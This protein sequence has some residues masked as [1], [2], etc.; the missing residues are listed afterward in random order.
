MRPPRNRGYYFSPPPPPPPRG[1]LERTAAWLSENRTTIAVVIAFAGTTAFLVHRRKKAHTRKRRAKRFPNGS[2]RELVVLAC[3]SFQDPLTRSLALDLERRGYIVF[4]TVSSHEEDSL[5][6]E[7][8]KPDIR[9]LSMDLTST[10]PNPLQDIHPSLEPIRELITRSSGTS[11]PDST[12][13]RDLQGQPMKLSGIVILPGCSGYPNAALVCLPPTDIVDT[14]NARILAP[15]LTVQQFLPLLLSHSKDAQS[16]SAIVLAYPSIAMS[17]SPPNQIPEI[18]TTSSLS[19]F[20]GS[21]RRELRST[22]ANIHVTELKLGNFDFGSTY[23]RSTDRSANAK[24]LSGQQFSVTHWHSS[25]RAA[26]QRTHLGQSSLIKGSS[27]REFHN[28][29]FDAL[30]PP[31][32]FKAFG[33]FEWQSKRRP[34]VIL[35]GSGARLYELVGRFAPSSLVAW[36]MGYRPTNGSII[37]LDLRPARPAASAWGNESTVETSVWER[38]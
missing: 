8:A 33:K 2:K 10:V 3:S 6:H 14:A 19:A 26:Q 21:L 17:L 34:E 32:I 25:Q 18:I 20:A 7:E 24:D 12:K 28:A 37:N 23:L 30:A 22:C 38:V 31:Q 29:V 13:A 16:P 35:V 15:I 4:V 36:M 1:L 27:A 5:V 9:P 11:S